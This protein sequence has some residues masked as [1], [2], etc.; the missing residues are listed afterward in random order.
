MDLWKNEKKY[1]EFIQNTPFK[2]GAAEEVWKTFNE[3]EMKF[4]KLI[5]KN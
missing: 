2:Q 4:S 3:L 5:S 1:L